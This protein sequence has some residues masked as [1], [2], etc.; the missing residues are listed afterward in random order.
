LNM[1]PRTQQRVQ[2]FES[3]LAQS[4]EHMFARVHAGMQTKSWDLA[5]EVGAAL[6]GVTVNTAF[7]AGRFAQSLQ[8][9]AKIIA[10]RNTL[11][12]SRQ[13]FFIGV[14]GFDT[15]D[16]QL[17]AHS[18]LM[19]GLDAALNAFYNATV[20]LGVADK[21]TTFTASDFGRT[22]TSNGDGTD[23]AWGGHQIILG[24]AVQG[25]DIYGT[26]P[27]MAINSNDDIGEGR[28]IPTVSMDQYGATLA[29]WYGLSQTNFPDVFPNL[30]NF[31]T[32][33]LGFMVV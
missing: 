30:A 7:P 13:I 9:T 27:S 2:T 6:A 5:E 20:E 23:H 3:L 4:Q 18:G 17:T 22:L 26:I 31:G 19:G 25:G 8:M 29:K 21:V 11:N 14:G 24:G 15:H 33:D 32:Q 1:D 10:A 16:T 12:M 28:I